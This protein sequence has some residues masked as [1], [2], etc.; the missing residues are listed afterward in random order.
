MARSALPDLRT[1]R[2]MMV[3]VQGLYEENAM[4]QPGKPFSTAW[5]RPPALFQ[6]LLGTKRFPDPRE[7]WL[8]Q[9]DRAGNP[10]YLDIAYT[11]A[12]RLL[13]VPAFAIFLV[14]LLVNVK[15]NLEFYIAMCVGILSMLLFD[16]FYSRRN[17]GQLTKNT[18][19]FLA[20]LARQQG[21]S[22][23]LLEATWEE[24]TQF[25]FKH[26][27]LGSAMVM[28]SAVISSL[29]VGLTLSWSYTPILFL[30]ASLA[31]MMAFLCYLVY[32]DWV[33]YPIKKL[34]VQHGLRMDKILAA[35]TMM[36][37]QTKVS[38]VFGLAGIVCLIFL[39]S[40]GYNRA[41]IEGADALSLL[42]QFF[43]VVTISTSFMMAF[44][45]FLA[46]SILTSINDL[47]GAM[48]QVAAGDFSARV[49]VASADEL[50]QICQGFNDMAAQLDRSQ[51]ERREFRRQLALAQEAEKNRLARELHDTVMSEI[52]VIQRGLEFFEM[53]LSGPE[54]VKAMLVD[55]QDHLRQVNQRLRQVCGELASDLVVSKGLDQALGELLR[56][57]KRRYPACP[58][59]VL[60]TAAYTAGILGETE[61]LEVYRC[62]QQALVNAINHARASKIDVYVSCTGEQFQASVTDDGDGFDLAGE[63]AFRAVGHLGLQSMRGRMDIAG[64][65][66]SILSE[67][68]Q[69]THIIF[70]VPARACSD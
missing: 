57:L 9:V 48:K 8:S 56:D 6:R 1:H 27:A 2:Y 36:T 25:L 16:Q 62:I 15:P 63:A 14:Y 68:G 29:V 66:I 70:C 12:S 28:A 51:E 3:D 61:R 10:T 23:E 31:N 35:G 19:A 59:V 67:P 11:W 52:T 43:V 69:G 40:L 41:V 58:P 60:D 54:A 21:P 65:E 37:L 26:S 30:A 47:Y 50:G 46:R 64:G 34:C 4:D 32:F 13:D 17:Y 49:P 5:S 44:S 38:L 39:A 53:G 18:R 33:F 55:T 20:T 24:C 42:V 22:Q 7:R 45:V